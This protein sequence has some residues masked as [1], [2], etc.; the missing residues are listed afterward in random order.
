[1]PRFFSPRRAR[2]FAALMLVSLIQLGTAVAVAAVVGELF[3]QIIEGQ[4]A[5]QAQGLILAAA[6][7]AT[8]LGEFA[9]RKLTEALG[10]DYAKSVRLALFE[11]LLRR[12]VRG[13][14]PR[15]KGSQ[16][17]P[18]VGD[19]TALRLWWADGVARGSSAA[20]IALGIAC[21][22]FATDWVLGLWVAGLTL[23]TLAAMALIARPYFEA[24]SAQ[25]SLRGAMTALISDR[26]SGAH[27][28]MGMGG[29]RREMNQTER[30][31]DRMNSASLRRA[32]WSG[33]MR[34]LVAAFPLASIMVLLHIA[35]SGSGA[36]AIAPHEIAG[37]LTL[38]GMLAA[39]VADLGRA[40]ELA[41]P[42]RISG[43]RLL[44]RLT[45]IDPIVVGDKQDIAE[46][47]AI[48]SIAALTI[49][50]GGQPFDATLHKGDILALDARAGGEPGQLTGLL[51]GLQPPEAGEVR[52]CGQHAIGL[53]QRQRR[54]WIGIAAP[55]A[56]LL[57]GKLADSLTYRMRRGSGL[58]ELPALMDRLGIAHL[59]DRDG[60]PLPL[61]LRD[62][63]SA[64]PPSDLAAIRI[65]RAVIGRPRLLLL[66][67]A[68]HDLTARQ[69]EGLATI[70]SGWRG[71]V[72]MAAE[73][74]ELRALANR[75]WAVS[76]TTIEETGGG[77]DVAEIHPL[78]TA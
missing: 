56:G 3:R 15:S 31:V 36:G 67:R 7:T 2:L 19:L 1:M 73:R 8:A 28:V 74:P 63:G 43:K 14:K 75:S 66:D 5:G 61:R 4:S 70:L 25:R 48:A 29:L 76:A 39:S 12:P 27:A 45:E 41:I 26:I 57:Q 23:A 54:Q 59:A 22:L 35:T 68:T 71:V 42:A 9:R 62:E 21:W 77:N 34:G 55:W 24:T 78:R 72:V 40:V 47:K 13:P 11:Q 18:F 50:R 33:T 65:L 60:K 6:I 51:A 10:L 38:I 44:A 69:V 46:S 58:D 37:L 64:L 17:L 16:L 30:R 20:L 52:I 53:G 49:A 32:G